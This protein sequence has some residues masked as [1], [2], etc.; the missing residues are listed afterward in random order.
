M[1]AHKG[2]GSSRPRCT[3]GGS[4]VAATPI[5]QSTKTPGKIWWH[6]MTRNVQA[7][8]LLWISYSRVLLL[9]N[10]SNIV[11]SLFVLYFRFYLTYCCTVRCHVFN[12]NP[13]Y[14]ILTFTSFPH[15][16]TALSGL[17]LLHYQ[18]FTI[19]DTTQSVGILW[20]C[21]QPHVQKRT[22]QH[23]T[24]TKHKHPCPRRDSKWKSQQARS[25]MPTP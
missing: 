24:L 22:L 19:T 13:T 3:R 5:Y 14:T 23:I 8:T 20:T 18:G 15:G 6:L 17:G 21:D 1:T 7:C 10:I 2:P 9:Q 16:A 4:C 12:I 25:S 11:L